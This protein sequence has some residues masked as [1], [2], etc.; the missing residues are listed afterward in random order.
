MQP[1]PPRT[2][3]APLFFTMQFFDLEPRAHCVV[4]GRARRVVRT[5]GFVDGQKLSRVVITRKADPIRF[6]DSHQ[7]KGL[8]HFIVQLG[9]NKIAEKIGGGSPIRDL[10]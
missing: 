2:Q 4:N 1:G 7:I 8:S 10:N 3:K 6:G 9:L 5:D